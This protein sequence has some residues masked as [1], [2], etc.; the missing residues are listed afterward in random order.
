M[1]SKTELLKI[2][3]LANK[4][5][6]ENN[7]NNIM[8]GINERSLCSSL[9]H[10]INCLIENNEKFKYYYCDTEYNRNC[11]RVKTI[12]NK[13]S[14]VIRI[15]CDLILHSRGKLEK[16]NLIAL[17]M[18]K[19]TASEEK[20]NND[21]ERLKCLTKQSCDDICSENGIDLPKNVCMYEIGIFYILDILNS[22]I[23][24]EIYENSEFFDKV[25]GSFDYFKNYNDN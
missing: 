19:S 6:L 5:F 16:D 1:I 14:K 24:L 18:K 17:E 10:E 8:R 21:R 22:E 13:E 25:S 4:R 9:S 11:K 23:T 20:M 7:M 12:I 15:T 2:F 3:Y